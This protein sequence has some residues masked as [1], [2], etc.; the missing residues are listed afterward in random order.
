MTQFWLLENNILKTPETLRTI[1][2]KSRKLL[3]KY[4]QN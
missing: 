4:Q 3:E 2:R 1:T